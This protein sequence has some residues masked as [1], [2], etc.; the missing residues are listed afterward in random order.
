MYMSI[1]QIRRL[2]MGEGTFI[3]LFSSLRIP[4]FSAVAVE[5]MK[6]NGR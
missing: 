6:E 3:Y 5:E 4:R 1:Q 2:R